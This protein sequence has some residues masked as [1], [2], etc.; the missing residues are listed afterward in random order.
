MEKAAKLTIVNPV[1]EARQETKQAERIPAAARLKSL[2]G[3]T[4][5]LYWNGKQQGEHGLAATRRQLEKLFPGVQFKDYLGDW[6]TN[7]RHSSPKQFEQMAA[8]CD[9]VIGAT[10]D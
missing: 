1:A 6:G 3:K 5:G 8:E 10:A 9:A 7:V 2:E 4:V